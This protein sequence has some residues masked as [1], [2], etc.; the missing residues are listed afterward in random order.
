MKDR[1]KSALWFAMGVLMFIPATR[2]PQMIDFQITAWM[3]VV[4]MCKPNPAL[5]FGSLFY[6][7]VL[8]ALTGWYWVWRFMR[9]IFDDEG[10]LPR[11]YKLLQ[12][13]WAPAWIIPSIVFL[14]LLGWLI[15]FYKAHEIHLKK[16]EAN[17]HETRT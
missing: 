1:S 6:W 8:F 12:F 9:W 15:C 11:F 3:F 14:S 10:P 2:F 4:D 16:E 5:L 7:P 13:L 17:E